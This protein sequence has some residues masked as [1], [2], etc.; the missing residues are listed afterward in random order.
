MAEFT[1][2]TLETA[3]EESK[4]LVEGS[5]TAYGMLPNLHAV[6]AESPET[7]AAYGELQRLLT[8]SSLSDAERHVVWL[9][10][11][12]E[13]SCHYC[14]P[15]H[16]FLALKDKVSAD[17]VNALR[18]DRT[19]P[20]ERLEALRQFTKAMVIQRGNVSQE[21]IDRF[22]AAGF[23]KRNVFEVILGISHK[24]ISNYVNHI[25]ETPVDDPFTK[26]DWQPVA[27]AAE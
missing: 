4:P 17:V 11:N 25:A 8:A 13:H 3:P 21:A 2:Y 26:Y 20:D 22:L 16:T 7:Y 23:T 6:L 5:I 27:N 19:L 1:H 9:T 24:V 12:V 14:V 18:E 15:A 10:I